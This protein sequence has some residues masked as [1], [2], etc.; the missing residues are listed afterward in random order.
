MTLCQ[1]RVDNAINGIKERRA[2]SR[3][4]SI[5]TRSSEKTQFYLNNMEE[6]EI[7]KVTAAFKKAHVENYDMFLANLNKENAAFE[8]LSVLKVEEKKLCLRI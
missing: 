4:E 7:S 1:L 3:E 5:S 8:E 2:A 6:V